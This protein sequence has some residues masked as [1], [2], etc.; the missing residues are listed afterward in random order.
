MTTDT[1]GLISD[2]LLRVMA[3]TPKYSVSVGN[4]ELAPSLVH[5]GDVV[6]A[7]TSR[8]AGSFPQ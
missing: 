1:S 3:R 6:V 5:D 8:Y 7:M 4:T 2:E